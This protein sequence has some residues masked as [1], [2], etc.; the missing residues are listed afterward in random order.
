MSKNIFAAEVA[1]RKAALRKSNREFPKDRMV[2]LP[3]DKVHV[4]GHKLRLAAFR[5]YHFLAQVF[6]LPDSDMMR[7]TV[8]RMELDKAGNFVDFITWEDL[9]WVKRQCG[10]SECDAVEAFPADD[11]LVETGG[12]RHLFVFP[13][14]YAVPFFYR[15]AQP[16]EPNAEP[17]GNGNI[18][19]L[20][21]A[22]EQAASPDGTAAAPDATNDSG[23][24]GRPEESPETM[25]KLH[26]ELDTLRNLR[27][28]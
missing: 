28:L 16:K 17:N 8:Q 11:D 22:T 9:A 4:D 23:D 12:M 1:A 18:V 14:G 13:P 6:G 25:R 10:F 21:A 27:K 19:R 20:P 24:N 15:R 3:I 26:D 2:A 7:L 5:S